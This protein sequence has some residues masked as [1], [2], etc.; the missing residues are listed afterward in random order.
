[1]RGLTGAFGAELLRSMPV[2]AARNWLCRHAEVGPTTA[3]LVLIAGA[4]RRDVV[5]QASPQL[6]AARRALL[7]RGARRGR[8]G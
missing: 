8:A 6:I 3:E 4:G 1:M 7:R 2:D 5:H